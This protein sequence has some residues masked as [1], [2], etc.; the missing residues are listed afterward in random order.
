MLYAFLNCMIN[1]TLTTEHKNLEGVVVGGGWRSD[2][3]RLLHAS[4]FYTQTTRLICV[5][6]A[7]SSQLPSPANRFWI[8]ERCNVS[9][10]C[11]CCDHICNFLYILVYGIPKAEDTS[12]FCLRIR[13][14]SNLEL[15]YFQDLIFFLFLTSAVNQVGLLIHYNSTRRFL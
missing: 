13:K 1:L 10:F 6:F 7:I 11:H 2:A 8:R 14:P 9:S 3:F 15:L 12:I 4:S 5:F